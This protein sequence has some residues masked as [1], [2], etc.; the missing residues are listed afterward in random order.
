MDIYFP[1]AKLKLNTEQEQIS[2][3]PAE[4]YFRTDILN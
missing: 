1:E 4:Q 3:A 2:T